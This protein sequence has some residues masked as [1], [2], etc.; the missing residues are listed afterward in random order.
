LLVRQREQL[1]L[2]GHDKRYAE[3]VRHGRAQL[4]RGLVSRRND[5]ISVA[6][7]PNECLQA[8]TKLR[9][10]GQGTDIQVEHVVAFTIVLIAMNR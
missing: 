10:A 9:G 2:F 4:A 6:V 1:R 5:D 7:L 8:D 3:P